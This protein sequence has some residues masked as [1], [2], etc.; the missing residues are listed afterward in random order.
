MAFSMKIVE[1][2]EITRDEIGHDMAA[3]VR[4]ELVAT[5]E[6]FQDQVNVFW[7]VPFPNDVLVS[8]DI[9][10]GLH[11]PVDK[12]LIVFRQWPEQLE[13]PDKQIFHAGSMSAIS[14]SSI[15]PFWREHSGAATLFGQARHRGRCM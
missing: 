13:L 12:T 8:P 7:R 10:G 2:A 15:M 14:R 11:D 1:I 4:Q 6:A 3:T 5:R 9:P